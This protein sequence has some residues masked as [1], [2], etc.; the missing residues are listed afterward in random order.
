LAEMETV[1]V[2]SMGRV[3]IPLELRRELGIE[4][5]DKLIVARDG[6]AIKLI[7]TPRLSELAGV[8]REVFRGRKASDGIEAMRRS[9]G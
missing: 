9:D 8:D 2:C 4:G 7:P 5:G 1:T 3:T 6:N